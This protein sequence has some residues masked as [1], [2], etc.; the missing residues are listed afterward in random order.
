MHRDEQA[1][2]AARDDADLHDRSAVAR[3]Q[4]QVGRNPST[5]SKAPG[6]GACGALVV[7]VGGIA[8][9]GTPTARSSRRG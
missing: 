5:T 4:A 7:S 6:A 2:L 8:L 3:A 1:A 9:H